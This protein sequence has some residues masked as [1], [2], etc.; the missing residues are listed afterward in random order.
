M[1]YYKQNNETVGPLSREQLKELVQAGIVEPRQTVWK[2]GAN[3]RT[4]IHAATA[5]LDHHLPCLDY[6]ASEGED[7]ATA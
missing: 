1:W 2:Q 4:F 3:C 6:V 5:S 7:Q